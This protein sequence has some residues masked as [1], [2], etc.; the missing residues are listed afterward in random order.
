M[1]FD[2]YEELEVAH[3]EMRKVIKAKDFNGYLFLGKNRT[4]INLSLVKNIEFIEGGM[5]E[6]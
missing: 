6:N 5:E 4:I 3:A 1:G 2:S